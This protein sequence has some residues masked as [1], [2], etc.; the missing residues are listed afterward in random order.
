MFTEILEI[1][2]FELRLRTINNKNAY[3]QNLTN[4]NQHRIFT[5]VSIIYTLL[6]ID[7]QKKATS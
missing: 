5:L 7:M 1:T 3:N 4:K 6:T 2:S